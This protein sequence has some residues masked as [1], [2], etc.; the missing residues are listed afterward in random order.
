MSVLKVN[1]NER[2]RLIAIEDGYSSDLDVGALFQEPAPKRHKWGKDKFSGSFVCHS[3]VAACTQCGLE[4][5]RQFD[6]GNRRTI[7]RDPGSDKWFVDKN[8]AWSAKTPP[9]E[10]RN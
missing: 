9:C 4:R 1:A 6:Y 2:K 8:P 7:F 5:H 10:R 3:S